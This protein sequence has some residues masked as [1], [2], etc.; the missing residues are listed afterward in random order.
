MVMCGLAYFAKEGDGVGEQL[1]QGSFKFSL[2]QRCPPF[3]FQGIVPVELLI[4]DMLVSN[5]DDL[6]VDELDVDGSAESE[7]GCS[8]SST[9]L[10]SRAKSI[11]IG[12]VEA[13]VEDTCLDSFGV[14]ALSPHVGLKCEF[15]P[16]RGRSSLGLEMPAG[17]LQLRLHER[18]GSLALSCRCPCP[19]S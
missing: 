14:C 5:S 9:P 15:L 16:P 4:V 7:I 11:T 10:S 1:E 17:R 18:A 3:H 19:P 12:V 13:R 8:I 6:E 2:D